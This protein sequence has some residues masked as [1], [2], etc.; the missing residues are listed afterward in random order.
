MEERDNDNKKTPPVK[1]KGQP[2]HE[3]EEKLRSSPNDPELKV[4]VG[5]DESMD[6]SDPPSAVIPST[7]EPPPSSG[8]PGDKDER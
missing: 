1:D 3:L 4:D 5:S 7:D 8:A 2:D 6:A